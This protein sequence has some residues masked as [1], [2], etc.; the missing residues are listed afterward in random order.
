MKI[1][2]LRNKIEK[3]KLLVFDFDGTII[4]LQCNWERLKEK[5][6]LFCRDRYKFNIDFSSLNNGIMKIMPKLQKEE[7]KILYSIIGR[8]ELEGIKKSKP[9]LSTIDF[10]KKYRHKKKAILSANTRKAIVNALESF[11]IKSYFNLIIG[12]DDVK[13]QKPHP[14]GLHLIMDYFKL[15]PSEIIFIGDKNSDFTLGR[16]AKVLTCDIKDIAL[17]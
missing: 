13:N 8:Y 2:N 11:K 4:D 12:K 17:L 3:S 15:R 10:I 5:L 1:N 14:E 7:Q 6:H 9:I 16:K